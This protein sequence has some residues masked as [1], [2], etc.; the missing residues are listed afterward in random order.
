[1]SYKLESCQHELYTAQLSE[2]EWDVQNSGTQK[3][4]QALGVS[5]D[6]LTPTEI[7][8]LN[9]NGYLLLTDILTSEEIKVFR[10]RLEELTKQEGYSAGA[11]DQ[12]SYQ[13]RVNLPQDGLPAKIAAYLYNLLFFIVRFVAIKWVFRFNPN[14]KSKLRARSG[15][16]EFNSPQVDG[17]RHRPKTLLGHW[18]VEIREM[19]A[20]AA[21]NEA[22]VVRVCNLVNKDAMFDVC[23]THPR[24]LAAVN[25]L[26][27]PEFK[28]SSVNYRA[29][30]PGSGLQPLHVD[31]EEAVQ[32]GDY[33]A[34][35]TIWMLDDFTEH[36]GSTR[37]VPGSN[38]SGQMPN[39]VLDNPWESHPH[40]KL[41]LAPAGSVA[42]INSHTWHG[43]TTNYTE[44]LR[45]SIQSYFVRRDQPTQLNQQQYVR[46]ETLARLSQ[47]AK[48]LMDVEG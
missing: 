43:G 17:F 6:T 16:P 39:D 32:S 36:N 42:I 27:G 25:H 37:V 40:Q 2:E 21:V 44:E 13:L 14:L 46:P 28:S 18:W 15:S 33:Y 1:M 41:L 34:C 47:A 26:L 8:F 4:L 38:H 3:A 7:D 11:V 24:V 30:K 22:G 48:F 45:R 35:N 23:F 10:Q 5:K 9:E 12:T 29:A 19:L 31:W 20:A